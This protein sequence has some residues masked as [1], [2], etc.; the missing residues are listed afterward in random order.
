MTLSHDQRRD[1]VQYQSSTRPANNVVLIIDES[2]RGDHLSINGYAR[3]TTPY[4]EE[5]A[6]HGV[7]YNWGEAASGATNTWQSNPLI[8][9][10]LTTLPDRDGQIHRMP[11]IYQYAKAMG[12]TT[13]YLDSGSSIPRTAYDGAGCR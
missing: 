8:L 2:L 9:T 11:T 3:P 6:R 10:G 7:L 5:L 1:V 4:L 13:F 12:Y